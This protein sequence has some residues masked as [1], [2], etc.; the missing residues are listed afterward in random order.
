MKILIDAYDKIDDG[1]K[2][3]LLIAKAILSQ[4]QK[5]EESLDDFPILKKHYLQKKI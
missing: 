3:D 4:I 2:Q 1:S 5:P